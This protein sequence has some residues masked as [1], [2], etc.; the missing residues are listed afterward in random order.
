M[1]LQYHNY[2]KRQSKYFL[3]YL[4]SFYSKRK[5]AAVTER[6]NIPVSM[7]FCAD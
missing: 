3:L 6:E 1:N 2:D 7:E 5:Q 4:Q